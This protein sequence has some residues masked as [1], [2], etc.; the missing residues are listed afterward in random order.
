MNLILVVLEIFAG[1][2]A[3]YLFLNR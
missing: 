2:V 3:L 1:L